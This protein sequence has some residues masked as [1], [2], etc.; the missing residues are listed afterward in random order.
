MESMK[1]RK[2]NQEVENKRSVICYLF[3]TGGDLAVNDRSSGQWSRDFKNPAYLN[4]RAQADDMIVFIRR[5]EE[6]QREKASSN[7]DNV[8]SGLRAAVITFQNIS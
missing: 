1:F 8:S 5:R 7:L 6:K 3:C 4:L 2:Q